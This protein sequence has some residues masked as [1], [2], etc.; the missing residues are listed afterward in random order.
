MRKK[1]FWNHACVAVVIVIFLF[2]MHASVQAKERYV[3]HATGGTAGTYFP[4]GG[5]MAELQ[6]KYMKG[7]KATAEVTGA[8]LENLRLIEKNEAQFAQISAPSV[9]MAYYGKEP[10]K[11]PLRNILGVMAM[12]PS[13]LQVVVLKESGIN[14]IEDLKGKTV[15]VGAPGGANFVY[16]WDMLHTYGFKD[17]EIKAV[18][19]TFA[20]AVKA[21]KDGNI[22]CTIVVSSVPNP[23]VTDLS[24]TRNIKLL[25]VKE[26]M[27][28]RLVK[29]LPY[30]VKT[31]IYAGSYRGLDKDIWSMTTMNEVICNK[32]LEDQFVYDSL[33]LWFDHRD[34]L[35]KVHPVVKYMTKELGPKVSIPLHP[36]AIKYFKEV[37]ALP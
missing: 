6:N 30:Y 13:H 27:L 10:F 32:N 23:A 19:L 5:A 26:E 28:D 36:G 1:I 11:Q 29:K 3:V 25:E 24:T 12:H 4:I 34:Y 37:G 16:S 22:D 2:T 20:E 31:K 17:K 18:Y 8:S 33:K 21:M 14:S 35:I 15:N 7:V 9:Y